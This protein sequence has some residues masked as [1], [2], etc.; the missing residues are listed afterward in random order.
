M[1]PGAEILYAV[2]ACPLWLAKYPDNP[3]YAPWLG[4]GSNSMPTDVDQ[5]VKK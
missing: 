5:C 3:N 2:G 1:Y 4:P